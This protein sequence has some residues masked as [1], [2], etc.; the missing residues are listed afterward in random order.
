MLETTTTTAA[1]SRETSMLII[2]QQQRKHTLFPLPWLSAYPTYVVHTHTPPYELG[3]SIIYAS[4]FAKTK[5]REEEEGGTC[6][7]SRLLRRH[8][9]LPNVVNL[10][11]RQQQ[12]GNLKGKGLF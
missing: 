12:R 2:F 3:H 11:E 5:L 10:E 7:L 1:T 4:T 8:H 9:F 6:S